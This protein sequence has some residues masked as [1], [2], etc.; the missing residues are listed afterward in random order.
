MQSQPSLATLF[1]RLRVGATTSQGASLVSRRCLTSGRGV[2]QRGSVASPVTKAIPG[3]PDRN[4]R[5]L[6]HTAFFAEHRP[7]V[8]EAEVMLARETAS[9]K[10]E[11]SLKKSDSIDDI[12]RYNDEYAKIFNAFTPF[13]PPSEH[14]YTHAHES[15]IRAS[16][17]KAAHSYTIADYLNYKAISKGVPSTVTPPVRNTVK[18]EESVMESTDELLLGAFFASAKSPS[19]GL[20][21][22]SR[23]YLADMH[24]SGIFGD[25]ALEK[26]SHS[27]GIALKGMGRRRRMIRV[28]G[29]DEK[30]GQMMEAISI[31]KRRR[32]KMKKHKWKK[33]RKEVRDS[34]RYNK[35]RRKKGGVQREK[36]E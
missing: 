8:P 13:L 6:A 7:L 2:H 34:T 31:L 1:T 16:P 4:G 17:P 21:A 19:L 15:A 14:A 32:K 9:M 36:Q 30:K 27:G 3:A 10:A 20:T 5:S 33:Q 18:A 23:K 11:A 26:A 35:E 24:G 29:S 22:A 25:L 28:P 12:A